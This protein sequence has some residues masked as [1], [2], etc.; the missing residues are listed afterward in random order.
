MYLGLVLV[1][2]SAAQ[3]GSIA[4]TN[5]D[6]A[7]VQQVAAR[8]NCALELRDAWLNAVIANHDDDCSMIV[9]GKKS[10][11]LMVVGD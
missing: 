7:A 1:L 10:F 11:I 5:V 9:N 3:E 2:V 6:A 4:V 8:R